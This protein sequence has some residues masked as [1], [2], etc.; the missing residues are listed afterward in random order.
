MRSPESWQAGQV[1]A[2][3]PRIDTRRPFTRADAVAAG[4]HPKLLRGSGFR[5]I[6]RGV[7]VA[8]DVPD[9]AALRAGAALLPFHP[10]AFVSRATAARL[11]D[12]PLPVLPQEHVTVVHPDHRRARAGITCH[13]RPGMRVNVVEGLRV[14]A[15]DQ[16]FVELA[17][18]LSLVDLV[19]VGDNLVRRRKITR[20]ALVDYCDRSHLPSASLARRAA[21][22]VR[23]RV[24]SAMETRLRML[25]VLAG[26]PEPLVNMSIADVHGRPVR[27]YDLSWP[28]VKVIVEYDGRHHIEREEQWEADLQRREAID[29]DGWRILVVVAAGVYTAPG[30][31]LLR[32]WTLLRSAGLA[33]L[34]ARLGEEW[35]PHFPGRS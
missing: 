21:C 12:V 32:I 3:E 34:P 33:G 5:R 29:D 24:D 14:S 30:Q 1:A 31:T 2:E 20:T 4:V 11:L 17:S 9:S 22:A 25:I 8:A 28:A 6:F 35:R 10:R 18:C 27:R 23:E 19:V 15:V 13:V 26:I 7:Y 16:M